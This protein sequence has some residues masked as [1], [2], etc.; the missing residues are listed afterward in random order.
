MKDFIRIKLYE[1]IMNVNGIKKAS[2]VLIKAIDTNRILL[3]LRDDYPIHQNTWSMVAGG[4]EIGES[5]LEGLKREVGEELS[6]DPNIITYRFKGSELLN[7]KTTFTWY[8][9]LTPMEF[10]PKL[11]EENLDY[12]WFDINKLPEPLYPGT[13]DKIKM[14]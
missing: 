1:N 12:G 2:G 6:I 7:G 9:G 14:I 3:L 11:D 10:I 13:L 8:E 4:I 5:D